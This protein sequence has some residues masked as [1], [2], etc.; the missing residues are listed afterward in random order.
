MK[1]GLRRGTVVIGGAVVINTLLL[2]LLSVLSRAQLVNPDLDAAVAVRLVQLRPE[3]SPEET[4]L[5]E[6]EPPEPKPEPEF[7]PDLLRP[8][9]L[10]GEPPG[11]TVAV[12][13]EGLAPGMDASFVFDEDDVDQKPQPAVRMEPTYP[14]RARMLN[15]DGWV[16]VKFLVQA[17]GTVKEVKILKA[18]P[19]GY[20]EESV[21]KAVQRWRFNPGIVAGKPV[22]C[23]W[24][25]RIDFVITP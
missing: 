1:S 8:S 24:A 21:L 13:V 4:R 6:P 19:E 20:F 14:H 25:T 2:G 18:E 17:D 11:V 7:A 12:N 5:E 3:E 10:A 22:D 23:W 16:R 9:V 15:V